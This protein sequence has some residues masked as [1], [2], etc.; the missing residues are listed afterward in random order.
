MINSLLSPLSLPCSF[1]VQIFSSV[2]VRNAYADTAAIFKSDI[3][4]F[5]WPSSQ[6]VLLLCVDYLWT[7]TDSIVSNVLSGVSVCGPH[8]FRHLDQVV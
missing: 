2:A 8:A 1:F 5:M 7:W 6:S 4:Q 3:M